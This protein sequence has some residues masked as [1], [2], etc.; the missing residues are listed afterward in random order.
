MSFET[1]ER[2]LEATRVMVGVVYCSKE[3]CGIVSVVGS[4]CGIGVIV[5]AMIVMVTIAMIVIV[6]I[7][8]IVMVATSMI[9][10]VTIAM[11]VI[12]TITIIAQ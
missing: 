3:G 11:I 2:S 12:V 8:M 5:V 7:A 6:T 4:V 10:I 1:K 9:V